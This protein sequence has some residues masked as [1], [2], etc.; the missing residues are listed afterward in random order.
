[1]RPGERRPVARV[2]VEGAIVDD[3]EEI[4]LGAGLAAL[5]GVHASLLDEITELRVA[6]DQL[7]KE[8]RALRASAGRVAARRESRPRR[9]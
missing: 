2:L 7:R 8:A 9:P 5:A 6:R 1:M 3:L 4:E